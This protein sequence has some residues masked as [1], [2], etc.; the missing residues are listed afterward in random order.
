MEEYTFSDVMNLVLEESVQRILGIGTRI[1]LTL[2]VVAV[3]KFL[4]V[5]FVR[6]MKKMTHA[7]KSRISPLMSTFIIKVVRVVVWLFALL[8]GLQVWGINMGPVIAGLGITGVVLGFALQE[9]ISN[10]FS[11]FLLALNN[12]FDIGDYVIIGSVEGT[13]EQMDAVSITLKTGDKKK[14]T[15]ANKLVLDGAIVN[16]SASETRRLDMTVSVAYGSDLDQVREVISS[17]LSS[18]S[19]V[20]DEPAPVIEVSKLNNSSVD[21]IVRPWVRNSDYWAV[22]WRFQKDIYD[23]LN[24][25]HIEIP[26]NKLDVNLIS[27]SPCFDSTTMNV[28]ES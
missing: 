12:P 28:T 11:G 19:D 14:I 20:L 26:Y 10:L 8:I 13:V 1:L 25:A 22:N 2:L 24:K 3:A 7:K 27:K 17:L 4:I 18:Y 5:L 16:V 6:F 9:T 15:M 23:R 21:F